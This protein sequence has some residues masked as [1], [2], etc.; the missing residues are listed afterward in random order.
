[1][2]VKPAFAE[3]SL[4]TARKVQN[5]LIEN[6]ALGEKMTRCKE[7]EEKDHG[8]YDQ[9][10]TDVAR[11]SSAIAV[12]QKQRAAEAVPTR[13]SSWRTSAR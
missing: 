9:V 1:M 2:D 10:R 13:S 5:E 6:G 3:E 7:F 4:A 11:L 12:L 8:P